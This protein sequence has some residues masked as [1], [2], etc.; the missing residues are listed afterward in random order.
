M[1]KLMIL[2][3]VTGSFVFSAGAQVTKVPQSAKDNFAKQYPSA[4]NVEWEN[5]VLNATVRFEINDEQM[6]AEYSN[7]GIWKSTLK[8]ITPGALPETVNTGFKL[9]KYSDWE[10]TDTKIVYY[11]GDITQY[12]LKV[13][14][15]DLQK[16]YLYF[17]TE[18]KLLR[19]S[20]TL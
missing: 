4:Q 2:L 16:K 15:N 18:G 19:D 11:P 12:R 13:E 17:N 7:K 6:I 20:I 14:K 9:S 8:T 3:L 10:V 1:K 5:E